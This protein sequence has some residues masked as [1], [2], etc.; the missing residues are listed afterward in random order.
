[1]SINILYFNTFTFYIFEA[2]KNIL[3]TR[4]ARQPISTSLR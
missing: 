3:G 2:L 4:T 1:M